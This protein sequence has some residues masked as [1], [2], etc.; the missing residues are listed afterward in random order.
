MIKNW[1]P[2][3]KVDR[4]QKAF[5]GYGMVDSKSTSEEITQFQD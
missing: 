3:K 4:M 2:T 1:N 5:L